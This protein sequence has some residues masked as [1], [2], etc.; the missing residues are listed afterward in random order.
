METH[1]SALSQFHLLSMVSQ[2]ENE[3]VAARDVRTWSHGSITC[4][5]IFRLQISCNNSPG[6]LNLELKTAEDKDYG[7]YYTVSDYPMHPIYIEVSLHHG[8]DPYRGLLLCQCWEMSST[9]PLHQSQRPMLVKR[10]SYNGENYQTQLI[11]VQKTLDLSFPSH[12]QHFSIFTFSFEDSV[13]K[14]VFRRPVYLHGSAS[15]CQ[16]AGTSSCFI[17]CLVARRRKISGIHFQ[18]TTVS[19]SIK[20][21]MI[22]LQA[23]KDSSEK[24]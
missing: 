5:G 12:C 13:T 6:S 23:T 16:L 2:Y 19:I 1:T 8:T 3:L 7:S 24:L 4:D 21:H 10:C 20:G 22:F 17:T 11:P 9:N 14:Q 18:N 15:V